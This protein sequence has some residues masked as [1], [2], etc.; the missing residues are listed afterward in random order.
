MD[1]IQREIIL[2]IVLVIGITVL[3]GVGIVVTILCVARYIRNRRQREM[4]AR[5]E[6]RLHAAI[7][8]GQN[9][10][11]LLHNQQPQVVS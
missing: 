5:E 8:S 7:A 1:D 3:V 10:R 11:P 9:P 4:V 2:Y 6:A